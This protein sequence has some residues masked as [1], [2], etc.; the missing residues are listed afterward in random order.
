VV[1]AELRLPVTKY[2]ND[3]LVAAFGQRRSSGS[4]RSRACESAAL[5]EAIR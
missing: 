5:V 2:G 3:T 4:G 1:T